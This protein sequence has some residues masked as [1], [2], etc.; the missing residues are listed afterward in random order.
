MTSLG[1]LPWP[2]LPLV[3][4]EPAVVSPPAPP[5]PPPR[6]G[7][8]EIKSIARS[9]LIKL[10]PLPLLE[11]LETSFNFSLAMPNHCNLANSVITRQARRSSLIAVSLSCLSQPQLIVSSPSLDIWTIP[12]EGSHLNLQATFEGAGFRGQWG[13]RCG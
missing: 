3:S 8:G 13:Q 11:L 12:Q 1:P 5:P 7:K 9:L 6:Q 10:F 4:S 2:S